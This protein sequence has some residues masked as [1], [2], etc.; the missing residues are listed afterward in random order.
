M[1]NR[2]LTT[3]A[4]STAVLFAAPALAADLDRMMYAHDA[5]AAGLPAVSGVNWK[6]AGFASQLTFDEMDV[7][8]YG[9]VGAVSVP[10]GHSW[11]AQFDAVF[12]SADGDAFYGAAAHVF[13]RD[14][15]KGLV[16]LY[17]SYLAWDADGTVPA[18][19]GD[20]IGIADVTGAHVGKIG[21][22]AEYYHDRMSLEGQLT[23]QFGNEDSVAGDVTLAYYLHDNLRL[24]G[25]YRYL[26][27]VGSM[28]TVGIEWAPTDHASLFADA[29]FGEDDYARLTG[30]L[31]LYFNQGSD[32][33]LIRRHREDILEVELPDDLFLEIGDARCPDGYF[34]HGD[35][36]CILNDP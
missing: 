26:N 23:Y 14:P 13:W 5:P 17:G 6:L 4:L 7:T 16:G 27:G 1:R 24:D 10:L 31:T 33:S 18:P 8:A 30:G 3:T 21:I 28:G 32:T 36:L 19:I 15:S 2:F 20:D 29:A 12:G 9:A 11:G 25:G 34:L 35:G 22:E